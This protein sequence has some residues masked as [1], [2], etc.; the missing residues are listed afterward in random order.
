MFR[1]NIITCNSTLTFQWKK[2]SISEHLFIPPQKQ[3]LPRKW[4]MAVT[5]LAL[6]SKIHSFQ[7]PLL[8]HFLGLLVKIWIQC[9]MRCWAEWHRRY[10][11]CEE[12]RVFV[13]ASDVENLNSYTSINGAALS[14]PWKAGVCEGKRGW[15]RIK[16]V[17]TGREDECKE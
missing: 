2:R 3:H 1:I 5:Y 13:L 6:K 14:N 7:N 17:R 8:A 16:K 9:L 11:G 12:I 4:F 10:P 15:G